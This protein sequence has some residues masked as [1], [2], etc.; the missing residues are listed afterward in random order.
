[1][2]FTDELTGDSQVLLVR[3]ITNRISTIAPFLRLDGDPYLTVINGRLVWIVDAYT[4][5]DRFPNAT[6]VAGVNYARNTVKITV[7]AYDGAVTFYRTSVADPLADAYAELFGQLFRP[8]DE[9]T[10]ELARHF[11]YP[12]DLFDLQTR[13][14]AAYHVTDPTAFYN[15][16]DR[17]EIALEEIESRNQAESRQQ[18]MEPYYMTLPLPGETETGFKLI[19]P[20]TPINRP[21]MTAWMAAQADETGASRLVVYRF[22]RQATIFGPQQVEA[23]INQDPEIS[24]QI[25]LLGQSGSRVIRGNLLVIPVDETVMYVQP[26]YLQATA[27][28][29]APTELKFVI[30]ATGQQVEMRPTLEEALLAVASDDALE[31]PDVGEENVEGDA[32]LAPAT[33]AVSV[34]DAL[35]AFERGN[36]AIEQ[37]DWA[38]YGEAQSE[39]QT[40]LEQLAE[41][42]PIDG[43]AAPIVAGTPVP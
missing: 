24:T 3:S 33:T 18:P 27:T 37:G 30:V 38:A 13:V 29:G 31:G 39:L 15:G 42:Q 4:A 34:D 10:P 35:E 17:W 6:P 22:P 14:F 36:A 16:E 25:T 11:R 19:R 2:L 41:S 9:A 26:M 32:S 8:I 7:D 20:F 23:R 5:T 28:E 12:E 1:V 43:P 21:N 40:I